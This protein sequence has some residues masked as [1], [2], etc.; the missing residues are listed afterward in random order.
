M[1]VN[2][3]IQTKRDKCKNVLQVFARDECRPCNVNGTEIIDVNI[4]KQHAR[5]GVPPQKSGESGT[6]G[7]KSLAVIFCGHENSILRRG[8]YDFKRGKRTGER[9]PSH[10]FRFYEGLTHE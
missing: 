2:L 9:M 4:T 5:G 7:I 3:Q 8:A 10:C 1:G 6:R